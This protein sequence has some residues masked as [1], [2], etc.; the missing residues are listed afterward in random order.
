MGENHFFLVILVVVLAA[1]SMNSGCSV[2]TDCT[3][4]SLCVKGCDG[5]GECI[6]PPTYCTQIASPVCGCDGNTYTN[7]CTAT[8]GRS[9]VNYT[10]SCVISTQPT[11]ASPLAFLN[12]PVLQGSGGVCQSDSN[13]Q[14]D[15]FCLRP[16]DNC[17]SQT[18]MCILAQSQDCGTVY[19]PVC[20]C[21]G[22]NY[23][24]P[25]SAYTL[26]QSILNVGECAAS[27]AKVRNTTCFS[28]SDCFQSEFCQLNQC[29]DETSAAG[30]PVGI[31]TV[32]VGDCPTTIQPVCGCNGQSYNNAC[33]AKLDQQVVRFNGL[34]SSST[35]SAPGTLTP[36]SV[37]APL[38]FFP[39]VFFAVVWVLW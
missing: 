1:A 35:F 21:D 15:H 27:I 12:N 14:P 26:R 36:M 24:N 19:E 6:Q 9:L 39:L 30:R 18:G 28:D 17:G 25:C 37:A 32:Y 31:C 7:N 29:S 34:C 4:G 8:L 23:P 16:E 33:L 13:C 11:V 38:T 20:G 3:A 2:D 5:S 22:Y 10:G